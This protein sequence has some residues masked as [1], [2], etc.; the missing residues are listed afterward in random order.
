MTPKEV[1]Q[2]ILDFRG[3]FATEEGERVLKNLSGVCYENKVTFVDNDALGSA[4]NEGKRFAIL[5]IRRLMEMD[6]NSP[7]LRKEEDHGGRGS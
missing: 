7:E 4:F 6:P 2:T 1:R 3:T 5:H